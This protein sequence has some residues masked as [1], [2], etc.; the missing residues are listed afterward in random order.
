[1]KSLTELALDLCSDLEHPERP[2]SHINDA[3]RDFIEVLTFA[4]ADT[5]M[6]MIRETIPDLTGDL[7]VWARNLAY[8]LACLQRPHDA[9]LLRA[10]GADLYCHG[11][12]WDA[13]AGELRRRAD[14]L[15]NASPG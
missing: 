5:I 13:H 7:P 1:M 11:P 3:T 2:G 4:D 12:D 6:A 14:E 9:E 15:D 10:A 8:R